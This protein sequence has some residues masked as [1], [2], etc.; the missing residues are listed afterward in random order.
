MDFKHNF[1][2]RSCA[3]AAVGVGR[4]LP[5]S[6]SNMR[7]RQVLCPPMSSSEYFWPSPELHLTHPSIPN[8]KLTFTWSHLT[9]TWSSPDYLTFTWSSPDHLTIIWPSPDPYLNLNVRFGQLDLHMTFTWSHMTLTWSSPD[10]HMTT[11]PDHLTLSWPL[12]NH[13]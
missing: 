13:N 1:E 8:L 6:I 9:F 7:Q 3:G 11:W 4:L 10:L 12:P 2:N 5:V